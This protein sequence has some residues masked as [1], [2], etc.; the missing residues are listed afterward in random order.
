MAFKDIP[1]NG[2]VK[3]ILKLALERDRVPNSLLF[4]GP[5]GIGKRQMA[6]TLAKAL[7]CMEARADSCDR[8]PSCRAID[9][10]CFPDVMEI[11]T[12]AD[13]KALAIDQIRLL[14]QLAYL[15]PLAGKKR[16][17]ILADAEEMSGDAA[18]SL[19]KV[20]EEP[21]SF[22]HIILLTSS[23]F[24]LFPTI[25]S[26]C[27]ALAFS[28]VSKEEIQ[29]ILVEHEYPEDQAR[30]LSLLVDGNLERA[31]E[32][33]WDEVQNLKGAAWQLFETMLAGRRPSLFLERFGSM[34]KASQEEF[35]QT[36]EIFA[37]FTRDILLLELGGGVRFLLNPDFE[38]KL[39]E[40]ARMLP[41]PQAAALLPEIDFVLS[42]LPRNLNKN[43]LAATFFSNFGELSHV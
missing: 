10:G 28:A 29:K 20:L 43:L 36:L 33:D 38:S 3:K 8:C 16:V 27:Q 22:S 39:R 15:R 11:E 4:S 7:N 42:E 2:R 40:A 21:P 18:S 34:A 23:P 41:A 1:G 26:R 12:R 30:I 24:L 32:L 6:V 19:L 13:K 14:K 5:E 9:R 37:S 25:L 35:E 31:L 17:F